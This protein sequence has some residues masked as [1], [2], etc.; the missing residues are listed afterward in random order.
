MTDLLKMRRI[1]IPHVT[2]VKMI[3][4]WGEYERSTRTEHREWPIPQWYGKAIKMMV[5]N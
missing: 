4:V 2:Q 1:G 3:R 5:V